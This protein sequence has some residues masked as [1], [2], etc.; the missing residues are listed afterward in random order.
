[1]RDLPRHQQHQPRQL[2]QHNM[3]KFILICI[4]LLTCLSI[5]PQPGSFGFGH[6][7]WRRLN[8]DVPTAINLSIIGNLYIDSPLTLDYT[9]YD[10]Q[11]DLEGTS[12]FKWYRYPQGGSLTDTDSTRQSYVLSEDDLTYY[13]QAEVTPHAVS[14]STPGNAAIINTGPV[15]AWAI[16]TKAGGYVRTKSNELIKTR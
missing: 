7:L 10:I 2:P 8:N 5:F 9:Y 1:M 4:L 13:I 15:L 12:T 3:K 6:N 11:G 16:R 14:G